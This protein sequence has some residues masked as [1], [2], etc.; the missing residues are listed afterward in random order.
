MQQELSQLMN[1]GKSEETEGSKAEFQL[2]GIPEFVKQFREQAIHAKSRAWLQTMYLFPSHFSD[3]L[4]NGLTESKKN[5]VDARLYTDGLQEP[6][7][8]RNKIFAALRGDKSDRTVQHQATEFLNQDIQNAGVKTI[9]SRPFTSINYVL[10]SYLRNHFKLAIV[11]DVAWVG[12]LNA[13]KDS[14][15]NRIDFMMRF[16]SQK[17]VDALA[18]VV[19]QQNRMEKD[20]HIQVDGLDI[21]VDRGKPGESIIYQTVIDKLKAI[22]DP[23]A[24]EITILSPWVPDGEMLTLLHQLHEQG[25]KIQVLTSF[26]KFKF[27]FE[28]IYA[29]VKN[30]NNLMMRLRKLEIPLLYTPLEVHGKIFSIKEGNQ[31]YAMIT[32]HNLVYKGVTMGTTE[33]AVASEFESYVQQCDDFLDKVKAVSTERPQQ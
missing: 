15:Y 7:R 30:F 17:F 5:N 13:G 23:K 4:I 27:E 21:L 29:M 10:F 9:E 33:I 12:G 6:L 24:A 32:S 8:L 16:N 2:I 1:Y 28:G 3:L 14:D 19:E 26:H 18:G 31:E 11:D 25:A 22:Q 20:E